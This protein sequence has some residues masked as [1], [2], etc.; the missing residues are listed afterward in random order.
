MSLEPERE[1]LPSRIDD[2][3]V[4]PEGYDRALQ[5]GL[6]RLGL[7]LAP[8]VRAAIDGH[9]RLVV[10]WNAAINLTAI[11]DPAAMATLHVVDSLTALGLLRALGA[12]R[13]LD[14]GS[15][16]GFPGFA[17]AVALDAERALLLDS[18]AK[19][20]RFMAAMVDTP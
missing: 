17:L 6:D 11:R 20:V 16:A 18:V 1:P 12:R 13:L 9:V 4:L 5:D 15:G 8:A 3:P 2:T 19:K 14:L 7:S 10:V